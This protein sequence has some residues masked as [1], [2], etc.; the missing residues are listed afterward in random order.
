MTALRIC[1]ECGDEREVRG[2][3][4]L[5]RKCRA[6]VARDLPKSRPCDR[7]DIDIEVVLRLMAGHRTRSNVAERIEA[8]RRLEEATG[9]EVAELLRVT[10]RTVERYRKEIRDGHL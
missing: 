8:V 2:Q 1:T 5:R 3:G 6:C 10:T 9:R 4:S 7:Q